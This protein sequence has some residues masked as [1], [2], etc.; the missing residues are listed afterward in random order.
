MQGLRERRVLVRHF[1][2]PRIEQYLR[3]TIGTQA[4]CEKLVAAFDEILK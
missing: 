4:E 1:R 2:Q 3:I